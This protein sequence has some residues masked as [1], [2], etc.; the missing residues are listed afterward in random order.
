[1]HRGSGVL[2]RRARFDQQLGAGAAEDHDHDAVTTGV[3]IAK[4]LQERALDTGGAS[5]RRHRAAGVDDEGQENPLAAGAHGGSL[6]GPPAGN[7]RH[8]ARHDR[9]LVLGAL[10]AAVD[11]AGS[12]AAG[13]CTAAGR[14]STRSAH[15]ERGGRQSARHRCRTLARPR[16]RICVRPPIPRIAVTAARIAVTVPL[17]AVG[18]SV[19][20]AVVPIAAGRA[21]GLIVERRAQIR[22]RPWLRERVAAHPV[23]ERVAGCTLHVLV[24]DFVLTVDRGQRHRGDA[25]GDVAAG[26]V[27]AQL[28]TST[29]DALQLALGQVHV[30]GAP[31]RGFESLGERGLLPLEPRA[32]ALRVA[33]E[34]EPPPH[35]LRACRRT[36]CTLDRHRQAEAVQELRAQIAFLDVH[37]ADQQEV[38]IV[39]YRHRVALD[40]GDPG[41]G[42]IQKRIDEVVGQQV[43]LVHVKHAAVRARHQP[44][45]ERP[46]TGE[47]AAKVERANQ[48][49]ERRRER[50]VDDLGRPRLD[51]CVTGDPPRWCQIAGRKGERRVHRRANRR[52]QRQQGAHRRRLGCA[53]RAAHQH[54]AGIRAYDVDQQR[55]AQLVLSDDRREREAVAHADIPSSSPS[56]VRNR[57]RIWSS[58][59]SSGSCHMPRC[60]ASSRRS[61]I[62]CAA[63]GLD[64]LMKSAT[65]GSSR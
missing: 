37:R 58:R 44:R 12:G 34:C 36:G 45:L 49:V 59:S 16:R 4:H 14:T 54:A 47:S 8:Q 5:P 17:I 23:G 51:G 64:A 31:S 22:L 53:A 46:L 9:E 62:A 61:A 35:D 52:Q 56:S 40:D 50:D 3:G 30:V 63:H 55:L 7:G 6:L 39:A 33:L 27:D 19:A 21:A 42:D 25:A 65:S 28:R 32:K 43:D 60:A 38:R 2:E 10:C 11:G 48:P 26:A 13:S 15:R 20:A 29:C 57:S 41:R 1:V 18:S 24:A